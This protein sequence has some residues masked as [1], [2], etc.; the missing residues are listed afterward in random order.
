MTDVFNHIFLP[1][2]VLLLGGL[3]ILDK[4]RKKWK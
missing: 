2:L 4:K 3:L 1:M